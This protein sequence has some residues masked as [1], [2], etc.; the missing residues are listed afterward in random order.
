VDVL[1]DQ[2]YDVSTLNRVPS[3]PL[4]APDTVASHLWPD[5]DVG[6]V[7]IPPAPLLAMTAHF[8]D[9]QDD[10]PYA[11]TKLESVIE[12]SLCGQKLA[13]RTIRN[14]LKPRCV[15]LT[16]FV[17]AGRLTGEPYRF[18][19]R[20]LFGYLLPEKKVTTWGKAVYKEDNYSHIIRLM[21]Y[22]AGFA[23]R[24]YI[25]DL[26][27]QDKERKQK[28]DIAAVAS[29]DPSDELPMMVSSDMKE[30]MK[31]LKEL[32]PELSEEEPRWFLAVHS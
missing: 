28:T 5:S 20:Y 29:S 23:G 8:D 6:G 18:H 13:P 22:F 3:W 17:G 4:P 14:L 15:L 1:F 9:P 26:V 2:V 32:Y 19:R 10:H 21:M 25:C 30:K 27:Y 11:L 7:C 12:Y 24:Q 31:K 16:L